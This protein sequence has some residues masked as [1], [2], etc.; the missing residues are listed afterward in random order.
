MSRVSRESRKHLE[1]RL[2]AHARHQEAMAS[3]SQLALSG[4]D[5]QA[6][7]NHAIK[8]VANALGVQLVRVLE[9]QLEKKVFVLRA[10]IGAV[11]LEIDHDQI[12]AEIDTQAGF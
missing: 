2:E 1:N 3:L 4:T 10:A 11:G 12:S 8:H 9:L 5:L 6:L 7:F